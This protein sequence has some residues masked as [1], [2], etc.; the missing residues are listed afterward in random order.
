[1]SEQKNIN[2]LVGRVNEAYLYDIREGR[3][4]TFGDWKDRILEAR[5]LANGDFTVT[6]PNGHTYSEKP[7]ILNFAEAMPRDVSRLVGESIP[8]VR[9]FPHEDSQKAR[10]NAKIREAIGETIVWANR[11]GILRPQWAMDLVFAGAAF[12]VSWVD[13]SSDY[14]RYTRVDPM[15]ALPDV[16]NGVLQNLLVHQRMKLRQADAMWPDA[17][18]S[19]AVNRADIYSDEE[20]EVWDYYE[21]GYCFK[22]VALLNRSNGAPVADGGIT[23]VERWDP[24]TD[25]PTAAMVQLPSHDGGFRGMLDQLKGSLEA[26]NR[27]VKYMIEYAHQEV[28]APFEAKGII[29]ANQPPGPRTVYQHD[30]QVPDSRIGRVPPAGSAPQLFA[31]LQ[32]L[33]EDMRGMLAYP[34]ARQGQIEGSYASGSF[35]N[36]SQGPLSTLV[37]GVQD[38]IAELQGE[39]LT[40]CMELDEKHLDFEKPMIRAIHK[41]PVYTP[42]SDIKGRHLIQV[43]Y[44]AGAGVDRSTAD[45]R[46]LQFKGANLISDETARDQI[47]FLRDSS[48]GERIEREATAKAIL[49]RF[50]ADP[51]SDMETL[52]DLHLAQAGGMSFVAALEKA[53]ERM[54]QKREEEA[55]A[56]RGELS[57]TRQGPAAPAEDQ[58]ALEKGGVPS[59]LPQELEFTPPAHEQIFV[60][61]PAGGY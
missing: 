54:A 55:E 19:Q 42:H 17:G 49:Q 56:L 32:L 20:V 9:A 24:G 43:I 8:I 47:D 36:A 39:L 12:G 34:A 44:G 10:T 16:V 58:L 6:D 3:Q 28:Y 50:L 40:Q 53:K 41:Q 13:S 60:N 22:A 59:E 31:L 57:A 1:M 15:N 48:E 4:D 37:R 33:D 46:I 30:P 7:Y 21:A 45:V 51:N 18:L 61:S 5:E 35:I 38:L 11:G 2:D 52:I 27:T 23:I 25:G 26:K 14:P 29:N